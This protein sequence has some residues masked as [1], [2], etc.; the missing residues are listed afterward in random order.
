MLQIDDLTIAEIHDKLQNGDFSCTDLVKNSLDRIRKLDKKVKAFLTV[1]DKQA[2]EEAKKV[3]SK[4]AKKI[5]L[6]PLEGIPYSAKD[7]YCTKGI[8]STGGSKILEGFLPPYDATVI[9][10]M[11]EAGAILIGK[12]NCDPFGFGSSTE[13]SGY[14]T[15]HNPYDLEKV[16]GGS[17]GGSAAAVACGMGFFSIAGDTGGSIRQPSSFCNVSGIKVTYGRVSRYGAI[18]F[19]SSLDTVGHMA[20]SVEDVALILE[21]TAGIDRH[22]ATT[23]PHK[24][25]RYSEKMKKAIASI[26]VGLPK[27]Y[28]PEGGIDAGVRT[29]I[30]EAAKTFESLGCH[31][32]EVSL[33]HTKYAIPAAYLIGSSEVSANLSRYDGMRFG[34]KTK[35]AKALLEI[36]EKSRTEGFE[37]EVKRRIMLGTYALSAGY[38]DAY[39]KKAMRIRTLLKREIEDAFKR[40]DVILAPVAP[41]PPFKIGK[42]TD[43]PLAMWLE[44]VFTY[45]LNM[46]GCPG[47]AM[48]AG[49]SNSGLPIGMQLI[50]PQFSE[51]LLFR[52]GYHFQQVTDYHNQRPK[53]VKND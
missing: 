39:Y 6:K 3:D 26:Q 14:F 49:F 38:Y 8:Q 36:Y 12:T 18:A 50:G 40:V 43:D 42:H 30:K 27:E 35:G 47:L 32:E 41:T 23:V 53:I 37:D 1:T 15:T 2:L 31:I 16:P 48:P 19:S 5:E 52:L 29:T 28:F 9:K 24:V 20:R 33:P 4:V 7:V 25:P 45:P 10:R 44:D 11:N 22:D 13:N 17:S 21:D 51:D 46:T 34:Y